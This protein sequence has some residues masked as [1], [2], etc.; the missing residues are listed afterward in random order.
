VI[1]EVI[2]PSPCN[3]DCL[4]DPKTQLCK[5]C[6]RTIDEIISWIKLSNE[7]KQKIISQIEI[8]KESFPNPKN[9]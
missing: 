2:I 3:S 7:E 1:T 8:R 9:A 6:F 4:I 5:G